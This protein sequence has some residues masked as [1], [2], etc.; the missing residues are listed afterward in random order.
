MDNE[1]MLN[2]DFGRDIDQM[3]KKLL[4]LLGQNRP[5]IGAHAMMVLLISNALAS[6]ANRDS[7]VEMVD[8]YWDKIKLE[9]NDGFEKMKEEDKNL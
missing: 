3:I 7:F 4:V 2:V 5:F 8:Q 9:M 6:G 1:K